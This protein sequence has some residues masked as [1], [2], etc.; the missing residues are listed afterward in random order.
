M[1][2]LLLSILSVGSKKV[3]EKLITEDFP[4][5]IF[6]IIFAR[7]KWRTR[8]RIKYLYNILKNAERFNSL[9]LSDKKTAEA[10]R[11]IISVLPKIKDVNLLRGVLFILGY[12]GEKACVKPIIKI[13][14]DDSRKIKVRFI[15]QQALVRLSEKEHSPITKADQKVINTIDEQ[16]KNVNMKF[17]LEK[18]ASWIKRHS[19]IVVAIV[20]F[21][22]T[23]T[24]TLLG[25]FLG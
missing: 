3:I 10:Y 18:E 25:V 8:E 4:R 15:A 13:F 9:D 7:K 22:T 23:V 24:G 2:S 5:N 6:E 12:I 14:S 21:I 20:G 19:A 17:F 11:D 16:L 1:S